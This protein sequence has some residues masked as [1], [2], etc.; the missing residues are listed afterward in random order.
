[1]AFEPPQDEAESLAQAM[2]HCPEVCDREAPLV[3]AAPQ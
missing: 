3:R 2:L 1:M